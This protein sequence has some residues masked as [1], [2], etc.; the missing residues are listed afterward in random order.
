M[1]ETA[2]DEEGYAEEKREELLF[3]SEFDGSCHH[4][5]AEYGEEEAGEGAK[6]QSFVEDRHGDI[7]KVRKDKIHGIG[8]CEATYAVAKPNQKKAP[9]LP[10]FGGVEESGS[11]GEERE[12][13]MHHR[14]ESER[15]EDS[16]GDAA[17]F[18]EHQAT[19]RDKEACEER[20]GECRKDIFH[21]RDK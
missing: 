10:Y 14:E 21:D 7:G 1:G 4:D 13:V 12:T 19:Q 16:P 20:G 15:E 17:K 5:A 8:Y 11:A 18:E 9:P 6:S 3:A 2:E